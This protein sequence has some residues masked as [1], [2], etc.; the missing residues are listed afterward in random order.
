MS[1]TIDGTTISTPSSYKEAFSIIGNDNIT[2]KGTRRRAIRAIK[3]I[4]TVD[5]SYLT[6]TEYQVIREKFLTQDP[7]SIYYTGNPVSLNVS[8]SELGISNVDVFIDLPD[9]TVIPGTDYL[10]NVSVTF[11]EE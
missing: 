7:D 4:I 3:R 9:R 8:G 6:N 11:Y 5:W 10:S 2:L 1:W